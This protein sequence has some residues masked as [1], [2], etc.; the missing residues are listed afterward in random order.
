LE[1]T[2]GGRDVHGTIEVVLLGDRKTDRE[3]DRER[4]GG[5]GAARQIDLQTERRHR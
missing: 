4:G 2:A 5:K 3:V 1:Q